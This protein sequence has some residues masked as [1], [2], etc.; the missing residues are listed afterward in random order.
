MSTQ[1]KK[2]LYYSFWLSVVA[3]GPVTIFRNTSLSDIV[4]SDI[5]AINFL[6]RL[7]GLLA[8]TLLSFQII[9]GSFMPSLTEKLGGW[10]F[11]FHV[12]E[13]LG[14][15]GI[16]LIHPALFAL[17]NYKIE[18]IYSALL[19]FLPRFSPNQEIWYTFGKFALIL[20]TIAVLAGYFRE[21]PFLRQ[22]WRKFHILNYA[23]FVLVAIHS[24]F[25]GTDVWTS[26]FS[27]LYWIAVFCV[28]FTVIVRLGSLRKRGASTTE[29]A[30]G[31]LPQAG[32]R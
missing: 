5:A 6:Q 25:S 13:G 10:I 2:F 24:Y 17:L 31:S 32:P 21:K 15:W 16:I 14:T 23:G 28:S 26:P 8:F 1:F 18:G 20:I 19:T 22:N 11:R 12:S 9:L 3:I 4:G 30:A 29:K 27:W 7:T